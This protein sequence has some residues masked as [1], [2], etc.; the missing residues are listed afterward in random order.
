MPLYCHST[1][2]AC[3]LHLP[4]QRCIRREGAAEAAP[5]AVRQAVG[6]GCQSGWGRLLSV[7]NALGVRGTVAGHR[8]GALEGGGVTSPYSNASLCLSPPPI[9]SAQQ[10]AHAR[11]HAHLLFHAF[12]VYPSPCHVSILYLSGTQETRRS[13]ACCRGC[14]MGSFGGRKGIL[15]A[16]GLVWLRCAPWSHANEAIRRTVPISVAQGSEQR[17]ISFAGR[18]RSHL[19]V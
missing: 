10:L 2:L 17:S 14:P 16:G 7:A 12:P 3:E 8:P 5:E 19:N 11:L 13:S 9:S 6:G 1:C 15:K 4:I 18:E